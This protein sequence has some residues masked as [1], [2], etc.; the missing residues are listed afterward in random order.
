MAANTCAC[1]MDYTTPMTA[2]S[3]GTYATAGTV[4]T[5][6]DADGTTTDASYC[7]QGNT[8][9]LVG[10]DP[11]TGAIIDDLVATRPGRK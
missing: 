9:H 8:L 1:T 3:S 7:V 6:T 11:T 2:N 5:V 10:V 4:I